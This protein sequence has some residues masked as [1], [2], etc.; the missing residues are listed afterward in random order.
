VELAPLY[1]DRVL[2]AA[3]DFIREHCGVDLPPVPRG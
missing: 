3:S 1:E 2:S